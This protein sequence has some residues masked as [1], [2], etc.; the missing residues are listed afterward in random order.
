MNRVTPTAR[1]R[2]WLLRAHW[3]LGIVLLSAFT[4]TPRAMSAAAAAA[5]AAGAALDR[6]GSRRET[7]A[8]LGGPIVVVFLG[9]SA[10]DLLFGQRDLLHAVSFLILG[11]QATKFL[12]PKRRQDDWQLCAIALLEFLAAAASSDRLS[13][14]AFSFL[15][16][17]VSAGAMWALHELEAQDEGRPAE[18]YEPPPHLAAWMLLLAGAGGFAISAM[19]F[20]AVPRLEFRRG[21]QRFA[22]SGAVAGIPEAITLGGL[23]GFTADRRVVARVEFPGFEHSPDPATLYLRGAVYSRFSEDGWRP[24]DTPVRRLPRAGLIHR[25]GAAS[26]TSDSVADITLEPSDQPRLFTYGDPATLEGPY[27]IVL[28]DAEGSLLLA[29]PGHPTLRYR[30]W[31]EGARPPPPVPG[32]K[33]PPGKG[34]DAFPA[35]YED[36]RTL[37]LAVM[38]TTGT[39]AARAARLLRF[40]HSGFRYTLSSPAP[41]LRRFL[42]HEKAGYCEHYAAALALLLRAGGIPSRVA[43]GYLG[44]EWNELGHY[45][46]V[47]Q[48]DA[49]AWVEAWIGGRWVTMDATPSQGDPSLRFRPTGPLGLYVDWMRQRWNKYVVNYSM[50]MQAEAVMGGWSAIR[51]TGRVFGFR[52][53]QAAAAACR[54]L[55]PALLAGA[56][57]YL[58]SRR[59]RAPARRTERAPVPAPYAR[60]LRRLESGGFRRCPGAP[61]EEI[62]AAAVRAQPDLSDDAARFLPLYHRDR[63]GPVPVAPELREEAFRLAEILRRRLSARGRR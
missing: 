50:R 58:I 12:L 43:A 11:V 31:F 13:L 59:R 20:A 9:L 47:R 36:V 33:T 26:L 61:M 46:I 34:Y 41:S 6:S 27:R 18:G 40:F 53:G 21:L 15:F 2:W 10:A 49:H 23:T 37:G 45:L 3:A 25:A 51:H 16:L 29:Q 30:L 24:A 7:L 1:F 38:G 32:A 17:S 57:L 14:A 35:A 54:V 56:A 28:S 52:P 4:D 19:L 44:G 42:F 48:S 63:F 62:V 22:G 5:W 55:L 60:L 8:R 39:D